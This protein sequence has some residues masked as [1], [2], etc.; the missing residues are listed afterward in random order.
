MGVFFEQLCD[1]FDISKYIHGPPGATSSN[2]PPPFTPEEIKV[3]KIV[4]SWIFTTLSE[5]L[6]ARLVVARPKTSKE[7]WDLII[8]I[9]KDNKRSRTNALKAE[10]RSVKL[11]DQSMEAY[12]RKIE[13]L[14][15][16]LRS[17]DSH[18]N[19]EDIVHY[20]L[21][22]LPDKYDHV[23]G[24]MHHKDTFPDLKTARTMLI[25]E[26]MRLKSKA[27]T[28][29][30]DSSSPMILMAQS[31]I[32][33]RPS[34]PQVNSWRPCINFAKGACRYG[35]GCKFVHDVSTKP[36]SNTT[37]PK[38][39]NQTEEILSRILARLGLSSGPPITPVP[40]LQ[41]NTHQS[42]PTAYFTSPTPSQPN[43]HYIQP[44]VYPGPSYTTMHQA[45]PT[46]LPNPP[47]PAFQFGPPP[48]FPQYPQ[49]PQPPYTF[50]SPTQAHP[51]NLTPAQSTENITAAPT[52]PT[53]QTKSMG[54]TTPSGHETLLPHYQ[55]M[56][57]GHRCELSP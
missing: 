29:P 45:Q 15:T 8:D 12:F 5:T 16:V 52:A 42:N 51:I 3:D 57:H 46:P 13:S 10:L 19:D 6:Q 17:L 44:N 41:T 22:G 35:A 47:Q 18:V 1:T 2:N 21:E 54:P 36:M 20:A 14:V 48:G 37:I 26:E 25:T 40:T 4:L 11:G 27:T 49:H 31:G 34:N 53:V 55:S 50:T 9:V 24:I 56:E 43:S 32:T 28:P 39:S 38:S 33:R 23:V 30:M 7:A